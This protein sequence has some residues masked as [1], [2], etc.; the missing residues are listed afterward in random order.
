[1][2]NISSLLLGLLLGATA[3]SYSQS[4]NN[5]TGR[6]FQ[7]TTLLTAQTATLAD[8]S[9]FTA[10]A[11][12]LYRVCWSLQTTTAGSAG[13]ALLILKWNNGAAQSLT[14]S[15][16][17]LTALGST[18]AIGANGPCVIMDIVSGQAPT[19]GTTVAAAVGSPQYSLK[20]WVEAAQ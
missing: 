14:T 20:I 6:T 16:I 3:I 4:Y 5:V 10:P 12:G 17:A 2:K 15:T 7:K 9:F 1:M 19:Y 13:T 11:T 8:T 18:L